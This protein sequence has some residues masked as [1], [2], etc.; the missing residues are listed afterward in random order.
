[1][2]NSSLVSHIRISPNRTSPRNHIIDTIT[3]HCVVGQVTVERLGEIFA[4]T[5]RKASCNYGIGKDG[6]IGMYCEEKDRSWCSSNA[7]NDHRAITIEVA[8]DTTHPYAVNDKAMASLI[9]LCVDICKRNNIKKLVWSTNKNDRVNHLNGCNMTVHRD[10]AAKSCPGEYLYNKHSYIANEVNKRLN[11]IE[12]K[13]QKTSQE[14]FI[15]DIAK[16]VNKHREKYNIQVASP[17]IAQAILES[18]SGTSSKAKYHNYFGLKYRANRCP[19]ASGWFVDGSAEQLA[20]GQYVN[21][22]TKWVKANSMEEGVI[23]YFQF[24]NTSNYYSLKGETN[25]RT[26]LEKIKKAG[27]ATSLKYVDNLMNVIEKYNLTRFDNVVQVPEVQEVKK[28]Y[29]VRKSWEDVKSQTGA[30]A[31]LENGIAN[32]QEGYSVYDWNGKCVYSKQSVFYKVVK[33]DTL[34]E[35]AK[36]FNTTIDNLVKLNGI[37]NPNRIYVGQKI[38]IR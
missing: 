24:I 34:G 27:Y 17:I 8:S 1:M 7:A 6:R 2:S 9:N 37:S 4:P 11:V 22:S 28:L 5:S 18:A 32:C 33:G 38:K 13:P 31:V 35:I 19:A 29:R 26:Y 25:P 14:Q 16:Y 20:N 36:K 3:I 15:E 21:I 12:E 30:Y 23:C 10:Y